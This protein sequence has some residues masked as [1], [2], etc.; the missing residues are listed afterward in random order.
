MPN[1]LMTRALDALAFGRHMSADHAAAVLREVMNGRASD[2]ETAC[3][4]GWS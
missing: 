3:R 1:P 2:V 4:Q